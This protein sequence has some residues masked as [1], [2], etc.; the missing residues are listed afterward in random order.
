MEGLLW[1]NDTSY[2]K[3]E[4]L[5]MEGG[6]DRAVAWRLRIAEKR[7]RAIIAKFDRMKR[8]VARVRD[9]KADASAE[10]GMFDAMR[11]SI[12]R[13]ARNQKAPYHCIACVEA[14]VSQPFDEGIA[15]ERRLFSELENADEAKALRYAF[16]AERQC[17]DVFGID[18][19]TPDRFADH[20]CRQF[21]GRNILQRPAVITNCRA[22]AA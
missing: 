20:L 16:F 2:A 7:K 15:T 9:R 13:K 22:H 11:K 21:G 4:E 3:A 17:A 14:A 6:A 12:A 8:R 18:T 5:M 10:P 19:G 1:L